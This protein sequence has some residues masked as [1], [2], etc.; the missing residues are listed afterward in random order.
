MILNELTHHR[1]H[2]DEWEFIDLRIDIP[3]YG[4]GSDAINLHTQYSNPIARLTHDGIVSY[5]AGFTLGKGN[6]LICRAAKEI[7]EM[8]HD[9]TLAELA[10]GKDCVYDFL[11]NPHQIRWLSPNAG[12]QYQAVGVILNALCDLYARK[13]KMPLWR[14]LLQENDA[15]YAS[16]FGDYVNVSNFL[17][18]PTSPFSSR[19]P[20]VAEAHATQLNSAG[21]PVYHTT[22]IGST[23]EDLLNEIREVYEKKGTTLFKL[24]IGPKM[25]LFMPKIDYLREHLPSDIRLC[26][27]ANQTLPI[28]IAKRYMDELSVR[29]IVWLEE[30]FAPDNVMLF[31][32][33]IAYKKE[34]G[35]ST[36]IVTGENCPSPHIAAA[37]MKSGIDRFQADPCRMMG[38]IDILLVCELAHKIKVP[39]TPHA[40]GSLLDEMSAHI[41]FYNQARYATAVQWNNSLLENVGFCSYLLQNPSTI[42]HGKIKAPVHAGFL[43]DFS[44]CIESKFIDFRKGITWEKL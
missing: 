18:T 9:K 5:G 23:P 11:A 44:A 37:L 42:V 38:M 19:I 1:F 14:L 33:L 34:H 32:E 40:G 24:K 20:D 7:I 4:K 29:G 41:S 3:M 31:Q 21:L 27:D 17:H 10:E 39:V 13:A 12:V 15:S 28:H 35:L 8:Y 22:W 43:G 16:F 25:D 36:E 2:K 30:P 6:D 26:V